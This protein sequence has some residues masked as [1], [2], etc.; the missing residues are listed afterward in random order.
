MLRI[1]K[2][3]AGLQNAQMGCGT[4]M[5]LPITRKTKIKARC[6]FMMCNSY[7]GKLFN[8]HNINTDSCQT[9]E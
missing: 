2:V 7:P 8:Q 1:L 5:S 3:R 6:K 4:G 9:F